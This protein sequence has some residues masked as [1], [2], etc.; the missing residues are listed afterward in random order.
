MS[1]EIQ[2]QSGYSDQKVIY[3]IKIM[4][5]LRYFVLFSFNVGFSQAPT[6]QFDKT[7]GGSTNDL[8]KKLVKTPNGFMALGFSNSQ[9]SGDKTIVN[10]AFN[11]NDIW[12]INIDENFNLISQLS[13]EH[14]NP[15]NLLND[16]ETNLYQDNS[17]FYF[18]VTRDNL[19]IFESRIHQFDFLNENHNVILPGNLSQCTNSQTF[20]D[21]TISNYFKTSDLNYLYSATSG[22]QQATCLSFSSSNFLIQ[23][24]SS[25]TFNSVIWSKEYGGSNYEELKNTFEI[26]NGYLLVGNSNSNISQDKTENSRG[27]VDFW[28]IKTDFL[29]N[30]VWQKTIGGSSNDNVSSAIILDDGYILAGTSS[31]NI[32]GEKTEVSIGGKDF[33]LVKID[34]N[35]TI[36]WQKT[37]GGLLDDEL[38]KVILTNDNNILIIGNSNSNIGGNKTENSFGS[39]D[40]WL[41]KINQ[42]GNVIWD[43]TIGGNL[44]ESVNDII[45][46]I[47]NGYLISISS[48]SSISGNKTEN[49]RGG[50][51]Y[52]FVKL[53]S[54]NLSNSTF[55][56]SLV[57]IYPNPTSD[58]LYIDNPNFEKINSLEIIS[59]NGTIVKQEN[60]ISNLQSINVSNL[61]SGVYFVKIQINNEVL[62]YKFIKK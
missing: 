51:D 37:I 9:V 5:L 34:F 7:F 22:I 18:S 2:T 24:S 48:N 27:L 17:S 29:G 3:K 13:Y 30:I 53:T 45:Q 12:T 14:S 25:T 8:I 35:G 44:D 1:R 54:D 39:N 58:V 59:I 50:Y 11:T 56:K 62:N 46:T 21:T 23:K 36:I 49:S 32:S 4:K 61:Q 40:A 31:S 60:R 33:W 47:D 55:L 28:I 19:D 15:N 43:K 20:I 57:S 16:F 42:N 6:I 52:W 41:V 10:G 26:Q 38:R